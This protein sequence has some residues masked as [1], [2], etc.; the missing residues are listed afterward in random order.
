[1]SG[2]DSKDFIVKFDDIDDWFYE[3]VKCSWSIAAASSSLLLCSMQASTDKQQRVQWHQGGTTSCN[4]V[5]MKICT[6]IKLNNR[7]RQIAKEKSDAKKVA[8]RKEN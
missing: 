8:R 7:E 6:L 5:V 4:D 1:M 3:E 2:S